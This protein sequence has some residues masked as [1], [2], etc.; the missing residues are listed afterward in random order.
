MCRLALAPS[1]PGFVA[2]RERRL[3]NRRGREQGMSLTRCHGIIF[4]ALLIALA[5]LPVSAEQILLVNGQR[6]V[7]PVIREYPDRVVIDLGFDV[8]SIPRPQVKAV[9]PEEEQ[10][11]KAGAARQTDDLY[12][13]AE[14]P[15]R[16]VRDLV[17]RFGEGVVMVS[18]PS[19]LGSGFFITV[20]GHVV[21]NFH[22]VEGETLLAIDV[23]RQVGSERRRDRFEDVKILAL[24]P[25][26]DLALL[27]VALPADYK[28][29]VTYIREDDD[30]RDGEPVFA[31]GNPAGLERSVSEGIISKRNRFWA[32]RLFIQTTAAVNHGNS[33]GPLF[34]MRGEVVGVT[35]MILAETEGL[36]FAIPA[37]YV[38]D[39][40][41]NRDA[42]AYNSES[43]VAGYRYMQPPARKNHESPPLSPTAGGSSTEKTP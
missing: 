36:N 2:T 31:V 40:L 17:E 10:E 14:L 13:T 22:V 23:I 27:K 5:V 43:A 21:T 9:L 39:F 38:I 11:T 7:A 33:G 4:G 28:P 42:F 25:Y 15:P 20:E 29:T 6:I 8:L 41:R 19:A 26:R 37:R 24:D 30:L 18:T 35:N 12:S 3:A 1:M 32:G 16:T 34:N